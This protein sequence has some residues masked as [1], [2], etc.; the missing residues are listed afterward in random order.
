MKIYLIRAQFTSLTNTM[1]I[2][3][4]ISLVFSQHF[5]LLSILK[6]F[7]YHNSF[8]RQMVVL[9]LS[10]GKIGIP[11]IVTTPIAS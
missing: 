8:V 7:F 5:V 11:G 2:R 10:L 3:K 4:S 1:D 9:V 6:N